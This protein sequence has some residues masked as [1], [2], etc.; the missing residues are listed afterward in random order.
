MI[1]DAHNNQVEENVVHTHFH[2]TPQRTASTSTPW[3]SWQGLM[4][5]Y[6]GTIQLSKYAPG[7]QMSPR[8]D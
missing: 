4:S 3:I 8:K 5:R 6:N 7:E 2:T 1:L